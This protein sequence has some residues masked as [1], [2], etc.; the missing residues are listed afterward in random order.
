MGC[1]TSLPSSVFSKVKLVLELIGY[2]GSIY[3]TEISTHYKFIVL[4]YSLI[5][6][7]I[8]CQ[9]REGRSANIFCEGLGGRSFRLCGPL[10]PC[11]N[12]SAPL[13]HHGSSHG[14]YL[15]EGAWQCP[16]KLDLQK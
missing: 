11:Y 14:Q 9:D 15:N 3:T 5:Y 12:H 2:G 13:L 7:F 16:Y 10:G 8:D 4:I 6:R 1:W